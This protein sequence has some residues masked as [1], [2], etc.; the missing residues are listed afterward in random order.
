MGAGRLGK[1][2]PGPPALVTLLLQYTQFRQ[3]QMT[4]SNPYAQQ[5]A[6]QG[7]EPSKAPAPKATYPR[8]IGARTFQTEAEYQEALADF[9]N[10]Y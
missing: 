8:T 7:K 9:L 3:R 5:I 1:R 10:G 2:T 4:A 6:Q